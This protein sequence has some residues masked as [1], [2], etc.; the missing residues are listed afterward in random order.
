MFLFAF[1]KA[2]NFLNMLLWKLFENT[3][4]E[5]NKALSNSKIQ[6]SYCRGEK[7]HFKPKILVSHTK[8][9]E[10]FEEKFL[11]FPM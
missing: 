9:C 2:Y 1:L 10:F 6:L 7:T 5:K 3:L 8:I 4:C 11:I